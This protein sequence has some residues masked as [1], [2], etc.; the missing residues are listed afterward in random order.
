VLNGMA[1]ADLMRGLGGNDTYVRDH[2][3]DVVDESLA[4]SGGFDTVQSSLAINLSDGPRFKG[5]VE[6]A[7]LT[8]S[9]GLNVFGN[10]L[11]NI[12]I[13][14]AGAN[15]LNGL[16]GNDSLRG[17]GGNDRLY[18]SDGNDTLAGGGG[19]DIF[20][21]NTALN[22]S[23]NV[24][25]ITDFSAPADTIWLEDAIF[26]TLTTRG[27][28]AASAFHIGT[29]ATTA[30]QHVLYNAT[31]GWLSYDADGNGAAAAIHFA[32]LTTHPTITSGD[33]VVV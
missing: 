27:A 26:T 17:M 21:F 10:V 29:S 1:G 25:T 6:G 30:A 5:G 9:A 11:T 3:N 16:A 4:G 19:N 33:F 31:T 23:T 24:D 22:A 13:G 14:N 8:V 2:A 28:L 7:M 32:T 12:L 15:T 20:V 18:G